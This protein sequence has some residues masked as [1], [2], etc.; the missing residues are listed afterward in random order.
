MMIR[1]Q[2]ETNP[3]LEIALDGIIISANSAFEELSGYREERINAKSISSILRIANGALETGCEVSITKPNGKEVRSLAMISTV[4]DYSMR[5]YRYHVSLVDMSSIPTIRDKIDAVEIDKKTFESEMRTF[6]SHVSHDLRTP[7]V[8]I[9][10]FSLE[11]KAILTEL[12]EHVAGCQVRTSICR[13]NFQER[14][15]GALEA[16]DYVESSSARV[17]RLVNSL[18]GLYKVGTSQLN[19]TVV[20]TNN[21][22][23]NILLSM[24]HQIDQKKCQVRLEKTP[25]LKMDPSIAERIFANILDNAIKYLVAGRP[26]ELAIESWP[27]D[28][29]IIFSI[30][31]NGIGI[32]DNCS[33]LVFRLF[34]RANDREETP[35]DGVGMTMVKAL[36]NLYNGRIWYTSTPDKGTTFFVAFPLMMVVMD[37]KGSDL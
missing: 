25:L 33:E 31:D 26:G 8:S 21:M 28:A 32:D 22:I 9:K 15:D 36:V 6:V 23:K 4:F 20:N 3:T 24:Q 17:E 11:L 37:T 27:S 7:L 5:P 14:Y 13:E 19:D 29:E 34:G 35:G 2:N 16:I 30:K 10:G 18:V 12:A 1:A